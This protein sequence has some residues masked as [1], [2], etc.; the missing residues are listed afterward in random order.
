MTIKCAIKDDEPL[1]LR[2]L[3]SYVKKTP[4]LEL[5]GAYSSAIQAMELLNGH[6]VDLIFLDIQ[7]PELNAR[8]ISKIIPNSTRI[9]FTTDNKQYA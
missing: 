2:L 1:A 6:P 8:E 5:C 4:S 3:E 7:M 9:I